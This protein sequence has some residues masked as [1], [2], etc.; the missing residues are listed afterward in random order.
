MSKVGDT[1][2]PGQV[3]DYGTEATLSSMD[4]KL[5]S[6]IIGLASTCIALR[7]QLRKA[8][9]LLSK[10]QQGSASSLQEIRRLTNTL[11]CLASNVINVDMVGYAALYREA[12]RALAEM[13][14][15][16]DR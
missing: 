12:E 11:S 1:L 9:S 2:T 14:V 4:R 15:S 6:R 13:G 3:T 7:E 10:A 5:N 16:D 8:Q